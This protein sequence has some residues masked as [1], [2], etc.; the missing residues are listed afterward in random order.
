MICLVVAG[1]KGVQKFRLIGQFGDGE[2][3][4]MPIYF[5]IDSS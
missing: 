5:W 3:F 1:V 4:R 2:S